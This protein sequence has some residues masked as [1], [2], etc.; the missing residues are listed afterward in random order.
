MS[1]TEIKEQ[2]RQMSAVEREE[3]V[4]TLLELREQEGS[5]S[6][7]A[8]TFADAKAYVFDNYGD[9]LKRLAQ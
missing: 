6:K 2:L 4:R 3:I 1:V 7:P 8:E 9:L 5:A